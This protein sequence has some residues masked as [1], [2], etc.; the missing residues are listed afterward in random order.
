MSI[1]ITSRSP[2]PARGYGKSCG[3]DVLQ[4]IREIDDATKA[5]FFRFQF[6]LEPVAGRW[7]GG[8]AHSK[9]ESPGTRVPDHSTAWCGCQN[10]RAG[11]DVGRSGR[12]L[13][14]AAG[15]LGLLAG[16]SWQPALASAPRFY[17]GRRAMEP[18]WS[19]GGGRS[20]PPRVARCRCS[21]LKS[22]PARSSPRCCPCPESV[23]RPAATVRE[24]SS[25]TPA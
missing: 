18:A 4:W 8:P 17:R 15:E 19:P 21:T 11:H 25:N 13:T 23:P 1:G 22:D 5:R 3:C 10:W 6:C 24:A 16:R 12:P 9:R 20:F 2:H 14:A 7:S